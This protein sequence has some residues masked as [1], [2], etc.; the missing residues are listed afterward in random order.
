[1]SHIVRLAPRALVVAAAALALT[2][3]AQIQ[4]MSTEEVLRC[5]GATLLGAGVGYAVSGGDGV[6]AAAGGV[7][8]ALGCIAYTVET[9]KTRSAAE[10]EKDYET[11]SRKSLPELTTVTGY[12]AAFAPKPV[13]RPGESTTVKSEITLIKGKNDPA[14][15][16]EEELQ[17][18]DPQGK[19]RSKSR[20]T[21]TTDGS[22]EYT[23]TFAF[24]MPAGIPD[25]VYPVQMALYV[26]DQ[27]VQRTD[28]KLQV[29]DGDTRL[30][31]YASR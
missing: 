28:L 5:G 4:Q 15:K 14:P 13:V 9:I 31:E 18:L 23:N 20:K 16:V 2:S 24:K 30:V 3:C 21:L 12:E 6:G 27:P 25:G 17:L 19:P 26:N 29:A 1:M 7:L 8:A 10:V 11:A 22:G